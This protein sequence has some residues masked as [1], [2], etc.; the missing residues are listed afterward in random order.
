MLTKELFKKGVLTKLEAL[1]RYPLV[2]K[3]AT[4]DRRVDANCVEEI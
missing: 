4:V 3:P 1:E 2:A